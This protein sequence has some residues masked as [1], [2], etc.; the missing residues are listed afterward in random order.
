[1]GRLGI[2]QK[3]KSLLPNSETS[4]KLCGPILRNKEHNFSGTI[5]TARNTKRLELFLR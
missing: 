1:M 3:D 4:K 2:E 5:H